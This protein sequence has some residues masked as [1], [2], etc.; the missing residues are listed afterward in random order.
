MQDPNETA[1]GVRR[2]K[3][4]LFYGNL[5]ELGNNVKNSTNVQFGN[6]ITIYWNIW[7]M[8]GVNVYDHIPEC[9]KIFGRR[10]LHYVW[11]DPYIDHR[12]FLRDDYKRSLIYPCSR[13][14][15]EVKRKIKKDNFRFHGMLLHIFNMACRLR[16]FKGRQ[17][18]KYG[19]LKQWWKNKTIEAFR[20]RAQCMIDQYSSYKLEQIGLNVS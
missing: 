1:P 13:S 10:G 2:S 6:K 5:Q 15:H 11:G 4:P 7:S 18:D 8:K 19:N 16:F 14:L 20:Q 9:H 17:Y 3:H 12:T